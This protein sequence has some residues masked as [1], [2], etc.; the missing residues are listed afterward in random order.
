MSL[1]RLI[2]WG[3]IVYLVVK[4]FKGVFNISS[5]FNKKNMQSDTPVKQSKYMIKKDDVIEAHFEEIKTQ[6]SEN[7]KDKA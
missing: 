5:A 2:V 6:K 7:S 4:F 1:F 3:I